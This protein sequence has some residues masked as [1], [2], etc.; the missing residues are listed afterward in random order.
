VLEARDL[1]IVRTIQAEGS[2]ARAARVLGIGQPALTRSLAAI[3]AKLRGPLFERDRRGVTP[4]NLGRALLAEATDILHRLEQLDR[5]LAEVRGSQVQTL[6]VVGGGYALET[7]GMPAAAR[8]LAAYP[9]V[10]VQLM[11]ANWAEVPRAVR[12]RKAVI[13]LMD[14]SALEDESDLA[15]EQLGVQPGIFVVRP[16]HPLLQVRPLR[17]HHVMAWPLTFIG[18]VPRRIQAPL[19][20]AREEARS[21]GRLHPAFPALVHESPTVA[22]SA[23][24]HSEAVAAVTVPLAETALRAGE[25]VALPWHAPWMAIQTGA[26]RPRHRRPTE[27]EEAFLDLLRSADL[28]A[29]EVARRFL[30]EAGIAVEAG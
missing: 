15:V 2:L 21:A 20:A 23:V 17:L 1:R 27:V 14:V 28:E 7:F 26:I 19:A 18:R 6:S 24:R 10:Q 13:G 29:A 12:E 22:L 4:T 3:E 25:V 11:A 9:T 5:H 16:G 30:A 8:M